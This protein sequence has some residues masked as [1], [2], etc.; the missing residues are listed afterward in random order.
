MTFWTHE[1]HFKCL[2]PF[3]FWPPKSRQGDHLD[4]VDYLPSLIFLVTFHTDISKNQII[5]FRDMALKWLVNIFT[6]R[7][8]SCPSREVSECHCSVHPAPVNFF[9]NRTSGILWLYILELLPRVSPLNL[10][11]GIYDPSQLNV[12]WWGPKI[13]YRQ[14][15]IHS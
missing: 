6:L 12:F 4:L 5:I 2:K 13:P 7:T 15:R 10:N 8:G 1:Q 3:K 9:G 11:S 14:N